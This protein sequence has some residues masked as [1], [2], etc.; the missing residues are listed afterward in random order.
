MRLKEK[1]VYGSFTFLD[2]LSIS[3]FPLETD[4]ISLEKPNIFANFH[5]K[6]DP[7]CLHEMAKALMTLQAV[8]GVVPNVFGKGSGA[9]KLFEFMSRMR[10]EMPS[11]RPDVAPKIDRM[12]ILDR[13]VDLISPLITQL[14]Y[15]GLIDELF[16]IT[17]ACV[18]LPAEKFSSSEDQASL[19]D[20][21]SSGPVSGGI[22][23][24][25]LNSNDELYSDLR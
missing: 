8:Y 25:V 10:R 18:K 12:I 1:G 2:E 9:K 14:T 15:E 6:N 7:T 17:N 24:F 11:E 13:Q 20:P 16:G 5:V 4:V 21:V 23:Q 3:W 22:K 19:T